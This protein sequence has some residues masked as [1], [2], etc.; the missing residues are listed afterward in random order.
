MKL[1]TSIPRLKRKARLAARATGG[2]LHA[3]LD[4]VAQ[5]EGF[6]SWSLLAA[7]RGGSDLARDLH[8]QLHPGNLVLIGARPGHG[9]TLFALELAV[10]AMKAGR[11]SVFFTLEYTVMDILARLRDIGAEPSELADRFHVDPSS[12]ISAGYV[13]AALAGA[14][15]GTL[16]VIDY[17]QILD[18]R[19]ETPDLAAQMHQLKAFAEE[20]A[21][22]LVFISQIDRSYDADRKPVPDWADVRLPNRLDLGLFDKGCFLNAGKVRIR[23]AA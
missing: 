14:A 16:A 18:Q 20:R 8:A 11:K 9:K 5:E 2:R 17:L 19:R 13:T 23:D 4:R 10:A 7:R 22:I 21:L 15:P 12:G 1:S 3:E 6:P